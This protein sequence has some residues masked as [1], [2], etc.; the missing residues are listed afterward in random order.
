MESL[1]VPTQEIIPQLQTEEPRL[2]K[3]SIGGGAVRAGQGAN[4]VDPTNASSQIADLISAGIS[5]TEASIR[6]VNGI[7]KVRDA[8]TQ[9]DMQEE[10]NKLAE[11]K[12][13]G[14]F[15]GENAEQQYQNKRTVIIRNF[16]SQ[17]QTRPYKDQIN[18]LAFENDLANINAKP[19]DYI[20]AYNL[21][22]LRIQR[23]PSYA[24]RD[25]GE[26]LRQKALE[27]IQNSFLTKMESEYGDNQAVMLRAYGVTDMIRLTSEEAQQ[28]KLSS[29]AS[30]LY[31]E[32]SERYDAAI[33]D[34]INLMS[35]GGVMYESEGAFVQDILD[36]AGIP[37]ELQQNSALR[38]S[39]LELAGDQIGQA[40]DKTNKTIDT[41]IYTYVSETNTRTLNNIVNEASRGSSNT[42]ARFDGLVDSI[43]DEVYMT[44]SDAAQ[45]K[46]LE[47]RLNS[48]VP[49][50]RSIYYKGT[51]EENLQAAKEQIETIAREAGFS[52]DDLN[53]PLR[54]SDFN[55][56]EDTQMPPTSD[57]ARRMFL[58]PNIT[59]NGYDAAQVDATAQVVAGVAIEQVISGAMAR[60]PSLIALPKSE[61]EQYHRIAYAVLSNYMEGDNVPLQYVLDDTFKELDLPLSPQE[62][63]TISLLVTRAASTDS[64]FEVVE[65]YKKSKLTRDWATFYDTTTNKLTTDSKGVYTPKLPET[66]D[67]SDLGS[68]SH[69]G[70][71]SRISFQDP[72]LAQDTEAYVQDVFQRFVTSPEVLAYY[73]TFVAPDKKAVDSFWK[74]VFQARGITPSPQTLEALNAR[75]H[76]EAMAAVVKA[77]NEGRSFDLASMNTVVMSLENDAF[78]SSPSYQ[79][80]RLEAENSILE[81]AVNEPDKFEELKPYVSEAAVTWAYSNGI[82]R[83]GA[84]IQQ[85][86]KRRGMSVVSIQNRS[87]IVT[88]EEAL[89]AALRK[90]PIG[91]AEIGGSWW[92]WGAEGTFEPI[93]DQGIKD[94]FVKIIEEYQGNTQAEPLVTFLQQLLYNQKERVDTKL[95]TVKGAASRAYGDTPTSLFDIRKTFTLK[96]IMGEA[97]K[98]ELRQPDLDLDMSTVSFKWTDDGELSVVFP[99][100]SQL[101]DTELI[102]PK[103]FADLI[104]LSTQLEYL[105][106]TPSFEVPSTMNL[107]QGL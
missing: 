93:M 14:E 10:L 29:Q 9:E 38:E 101:E 53:I 13:N 3:G 67:L 94:G 80:A 72:N 75:F 62:R 73:A 8:Q 20:N 23:D 89:N 16:K 58:N 43:L 24:T 34:A 47:D 45:R 19:S 12:A 97:I 87:L 88:D 69:R 44:P 22:K 102:V 18:Q 40:F 81:L 49:I 25:D 52:V 42:V 39:F 96:G 104:G 78:T 56:L 63:A 7:Y 85:E 6:A 71:I 70:V 28:R 106:G 37:E 50:L 65:Q 36:R 48:L 83:N 1:R 46:V 105:E 57:V 59:E 11:R 27:D 17:F 79:Q 92:P 21:Q 77:S 55:V 5:A 60:T 15:T 30:K 26:E 31:G 107:P 51:P 82:P 2:A 4:I 64:A 61:Q 54:V 66:V 100:G 103:V 41:K 98:L 86:M 91:S 95:D 35:E 90:S 84:T 74:D 33:A 32:Y 68:H 99:Q 76:P